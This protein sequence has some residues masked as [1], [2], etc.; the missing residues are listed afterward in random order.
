MSYWKHLLTNNFSSAM[1]LIQTI[2]ILRCWREDTGKLT[3]GW[4]RTQLDS[5]R[6]IIH[7]VFCYI[8]GTD[9]STQNMKIRDIVG[10]F[11]ESHLDRYSQA[12]ISSTLQHIL[13]ISDDPCI[14]RIDC[15]AFPLTNV[16]NKESLTPTARE[17]LNRK[18]WSL[19]GHCNTMDRECVR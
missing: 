14:T 7:R 3:T 16:Q 17:Y 12:E 2:L 1:V 13:S 6:S 19:F 15:E 11:V 4:L 9:I 10:N 8:H 18:R 5:A